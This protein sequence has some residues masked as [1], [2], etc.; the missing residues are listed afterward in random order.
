MDNNAKGTVLKFI[1]FF[2]FNISL[3]AYILFTYSKIDS[4]DQAFRLALVVFSGLS[5]LFLKNEVVVMDD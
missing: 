2:I 1:V 5:Y 4:P 3:T